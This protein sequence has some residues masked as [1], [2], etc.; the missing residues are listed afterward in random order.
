MAI[1]CPELPYL[2]TQADELHAPVARHL[3][4][5]YLQC[6]S[7]A[8]PVALD[9][10]HIAFLLTSYLRQR[11]LWLSPPVVAAH[12]F[13][14]TVLGRP[15]EHQD[16]TID[17]VR[18]DQEL[19]LATELVGTYGLTAARR[20]RPRTT[21]HIEAI[22]MANGQMATQELIDFFLKSAVRARDH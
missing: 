6:H 4:H 8:E 15:V 16:D 20:E 13:G 12:G 21:R 7:I 5:V 11:R 22:I 19:T 9:L 18:G 2:S 10:F 3:A 14:R 1:L 17:L